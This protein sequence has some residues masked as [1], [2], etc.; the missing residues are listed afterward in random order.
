MDRKEARS[1]PI[2]I[3]D[4]TFQVTSDDQY[5]EDMRG[6]FE[7]DTVA[8]FRT[9]VK[10]DALALDIGANIGCTALLLSQLAR[11]TI[12]FEPSPSTFA[13]L[14]QNVDAGAQNVEVVN[15]GLGREPADLNIVFSPS[16][17]SGG[18]VAREGL[19]GH[20]TEP[21]QILQGDTYLQATLGTERV[22]FI[23]ID[24]EGFELEVLAGLQQTIA[25][26]RP[27]VT[28]ELNHWC[29]N[30]FQRTSVPDFIDTLCKIFPLLYAVHDGHAIDLHDSGDRYHATYRHIVHFEY[31]ALVG[32]FDRQQLDA[33]LQAY[34]DRAK[35]RS[36]PADPHARIAVL[37]RER[38]ELEQELNAER[39]AGRAMQEDLSAAL[40]AAIERTHQARGELE[41]VRASTSWRITRPLRAVK[42]LM[43]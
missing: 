41:A 15:V 7:P 22:G 10:P 28:L 17:R 32:A 24:V 30:A 35:P 2:R 27:V 43:Q 6:E 21:I 12:G 34:V 42:N 19:A 25:T 23:K 40:A 31:A 37:E 16:H 38:L 29:L 5:L 11:R 39:E 36:V 3:G 33:F 18:F 13:L 14:Q 8:L 20:V 9:L 1:L 26:H 4:R